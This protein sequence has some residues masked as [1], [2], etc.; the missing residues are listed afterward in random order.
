MVDVDDETLLKTVEG[1]SRISAPTEWIKVAFADVLAREI[2][3]KKGQPI[4]RPAAPNTGDAAATSLD[5]WIPR[6][7]PA[8]GPT[9][10]YVANTVDWMM[11]EIVDEVGVDAV[12]QL[13]TR[14]VIDQRSSYGVDLTTSSVGSHLLL[15]LL[16]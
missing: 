15:D 4:P 9:D 3:R 11:Q 6:I 13:I 10:R 14:V 12:R 2:A 8:S 5:G 16:E 1:W 7:T